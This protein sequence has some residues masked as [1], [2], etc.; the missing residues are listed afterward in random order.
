MLILFRQTLSR[1]SRLLQETAEERSV[2]ERGF[3]SLAASLSRICLSLFNNNVTEGGT[4]AK[5]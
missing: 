4:V 2:L 5:I 1:T 3:R